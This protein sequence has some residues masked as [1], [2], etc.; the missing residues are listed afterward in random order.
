MEGGSRG[1]GGWEVVGMGSGEWLVGDPSGGGLYWLSIVSIY[2]YI[3]APFLC[4]VLFFSKQF[5]KKRK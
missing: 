2:M 5:L 3:Y 1:G 4:I